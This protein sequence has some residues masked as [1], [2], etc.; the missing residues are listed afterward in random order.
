MKRSKIFLG[1]T[2][3]LLAVV[4]VV[5]AKERWNHNRLTGFYTSSGTNCTASAGLFYT[6]NSAGSTVIATSGGGQLLFTVKHAGYCSGKVLYT[7]P[8]D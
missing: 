6:V 5:A 7:Q 1:I 3:G 2:T 4:G 8:K